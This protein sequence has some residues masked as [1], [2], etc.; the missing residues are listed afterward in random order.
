MAHQHHD[1]NMEMKRSTTLRMF[2][3]MAMNFIITIAEIVGGIL[4]GSLALISDAMHNLTDGIAIIISY[5]AL[6]LRKAKTT[7]K[8]TFGLKRAEIFAAVINATVLFLVSIFLFYEAIKR[9]IDPQHIEGRMMIIVASIG[10]I[11]NVTGTLLLHRDAKANINIKSAYL[12]LLVDSL[13][14]VTVIIGGIL[15]TVYSIY[16]IDPLLTILIAL[17]VL[18]ESILILKESSHILMEGA[19]SKIDLKKIQTDL[20]KIT[21]VA[22]IH[23]IH[24]WSIGE[25]DVHFEAH[26]DISDMLIS[27]TQKIQDKIEDKLGDH[28]ITHVT[29]QFECDICHNKNLINEH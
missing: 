21:D 5:I 1:H 13:S 10:L 14:S 27:E 11:A 29:L 28:G 19:P 4:S 15:I 3:T 17:Y 9:F 20:E 12:H 23:H 26:V 18:K 2:L 16:W 25:K 6:K 7:N 8:H 22:G 24:V